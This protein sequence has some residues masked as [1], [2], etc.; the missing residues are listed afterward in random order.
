MCELRTKYG[1]CRSRVGPTLSSND[2]ALIGRFL[3]NCF[4]RARRWFWFV[5]CEQTLVTAGPDS[6]VVVHDSAIISCSL[7][8]LYFCM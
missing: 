5:I 2:V 6:V 3:T 7:L 1:A 8:I 4:R